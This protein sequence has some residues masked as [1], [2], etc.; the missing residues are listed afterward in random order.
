[1]GAALSAQRQDVVKPP[2]DPFR[3][4]GARAD[5][6]IVQS[7]EPVLVTM[8]YD[9]GWW[10]L[11]IP[12]WDVTTYVVDETD[13]LEAIREAVAFELDVDPSPFQFDLV[14]VESAARR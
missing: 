1:V 13:A 8:E 3:P 9:D 7:S 12:A 6:W 4:T 2:C 14:R 5:A 11:T 10:S